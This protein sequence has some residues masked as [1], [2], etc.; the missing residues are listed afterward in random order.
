MRREVP[1]SSINTFR[2]GEDIMKRK[3]LMPLLVLAGYAVLAAIMLFATTYGGAP[4]RA[5]PAGTP[6]PYNPYPLGILPADLNQEIARVEREVN[7]VFNR[8]LAQSRALP[9]PTLTGNP[10]TLKGTG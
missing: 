9:T 7:V 3:R 2:K 6:V 10:P 1:R 5:Q 8:Y 4:A